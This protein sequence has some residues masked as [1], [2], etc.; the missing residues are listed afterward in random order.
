MADQEIFPNPTEIRHKIGATGTF[1]LSNVS[2]D[3]TI[4]AVEGEDVKVNAHWEHGGDGPLPLV[5]RRSEGGLHIES[6]QRGPGFLRGGLFGQ[7]GSIAFDVT[8]PASARVEVTAVSSDIEAHGL[9]GEQSFKTVSGDLVVG[10][11]GGRVS[12]TSVSGDIGLTA[13]GPVEANATTTSGD[14]EASAQRFDEL[15]VKTVSGDIDVR[16]GFAV[17]REH[18]VESVSGDLSV[19]AT[20]GLTIDVKRGLDFSKGANR[21]L[22]AGDGS[23]RLRFRS[24]SGDVQLNA[25]GQVSDQ[26]QS[27]DYQQ[28]EPTPRTEDSLE[29]LR[30]LERGE[31]DVDE[32]SRRLEG[33]GSRG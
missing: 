31:I 14:L 32:A 9:V 33:A 3:I 1:S 15:R 18:S 24:L 26:R 27:R 20:S 5:V 19:E 4:R 13:P 25:G 17:G 21:P 8:V 29:I 2:G 6:D 12:V 30:A 11:A 28:A 10:G 16:G 23:A 7:N 22:V